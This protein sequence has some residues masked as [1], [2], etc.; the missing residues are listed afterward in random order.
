MGVRERLTASTIALLRCNGVAG[1]GIAELLKKSG[2]A[3]RSIYLNFP[4]GKAELIDN[5]VTVAGQATSEVIRELTAGPDPAAAIEAFVALWEQALVQGEF[6]AGC[7]VLAAA[8]GRA[9]APA[10][11]DT[12]GT[13]F[14]E[15]ERLIAEHLQ[16]AQVAPETAAGLATTV[17]AALEGA[18]VI[19][20]AEQSAAPLQRTGRQLVE[21]VAR[22][23]G[24]GEPAGAH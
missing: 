15:W 16:R 22:H 10:A 21:L 23:T 11:A 8:M 2:V 14:A 9:E 1:T 17:V 6:Q 18:L 7:P 24:R 20:L 4:G 12:A 13:V 3:R 19:A 5:A